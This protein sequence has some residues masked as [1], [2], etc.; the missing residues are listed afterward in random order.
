M[1]PNQLIRAKC[2]PLKNYLQF[3]MHR[4]L[5]ILYVYTHVLYMYNVFAN[6]FLQNKV[7][8]FSTDSTG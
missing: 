8:V 6:V 7:S 3:F 2:N 4:K 5:Y 1:K